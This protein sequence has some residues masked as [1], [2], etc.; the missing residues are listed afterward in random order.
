MTAI[1]PTIK[2]ELDK[3]PPTETPKYHGVLN[4]IRNKVVGNADIALESYNT[5]LDW[6]FILGCLTHHYVNK[7][8]VGTLGC[9]I[10][11][12]VHGNLTIQEFYLRIYSH[13]S[14]NRRLTGCME[15]GAESVLLLTCS[16]RDT[17]L[18]TFI[19]GLKG[20]SPRLL[21]LRE[22]PGLHLCLKLKNQNFR[23]HYALINISQ[24]RNNQDFRA[25][26]PP[27]KPIA[28]HQCHQSPPQY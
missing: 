18:D 2:T 3:I 27:R 26:L 4:V 16:Y 6:K 22:P 9:Q 25:P 28:Y 11:S 13:R 24:V 17:A 7:R 15:V 5:S 21:S 12:L 19:R 20:G 14:F 8:D 23:S 10:T 1:F